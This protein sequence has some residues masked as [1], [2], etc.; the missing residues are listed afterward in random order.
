MNPSIKVYTYPFQLTKMDVLIDGPPTVGNIPFKLDSDTMLIWVDLMPEAHFMHPTAYLLISKTNTRIEKGGWWP[1]LNG[2][3]ILYGQNPIMVSSPFEVNIEIPEPDATM[4]PMGNG[5]FPLG[6]H[7]TSQYS[8]ITSSRSVFTV[9]SIDLAVIKMNPPKLQVTVIGTTRTAGWKNVRLQPRIYVHPPAD[10]IWEFEF[11]ADPPLGI[12]LEMVTPV[13]ASYLY[14]GDFSGW[15]GV[16][17]VAETNTKQKLLGGP[18]N[19][20]DDGHIVIEPSK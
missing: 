2:Q 15:K 6:E 4:M 8:S 17:I 13:T 16:R 9:E 11:I 5:T 7:T 3:R 10:G 20:V 1:V 12:V 18:A 19:H 14:E